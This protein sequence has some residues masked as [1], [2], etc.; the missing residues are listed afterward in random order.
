MAYAARDV[1]AQANHSGITAM[2]GK[3]A[4]FIAGGDLSAGGIMRAVT[5]YARAVADADTAF[6]M[7]STAA[8]ANRATLRL[9]AAV[10]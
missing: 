2:V 8:Q 10:A 7:E 3:L 1:N 4:H 6:R 5:S 9:A